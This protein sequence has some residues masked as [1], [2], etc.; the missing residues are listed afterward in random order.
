MPLT[1][2]DDPM[3][4][5]RVDDSTQPVGEYIHTNPVVENETLSSA[6]EEDDATRSVSVASSS[7]TTTQLPTMHP[8]F[9]PVARPSVPALCVQRMFGMFHPNQR[10]LI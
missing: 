1:E 9:N 6:A 2:E 7:T 5:A 3:P 4:S 10:S 8:M